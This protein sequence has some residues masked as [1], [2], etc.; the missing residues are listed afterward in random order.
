MTNIEKYN[1]L[2][3]DKF[4][5]DIEGVD[6]CG[7]STLLENLESE[8]L[9]VKVQ[10][11][12]DNDFKEKFLFYVNKFG[13][14][15]KCIRFLCAEYNMKSYC[16]NRIELV[17]NEEI[18]GII[19]ERGILSNLVYN[20]TTIDSINILI[21]YYED[22]LPDLII[23][24]DKNPE[25]C[26]VNLEKRKENNIINKFVKDNLN[27]IY[28]RFHKSIDLLKEKVDILIVKNV[29]EAKKSILNIIK[30]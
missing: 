27:I 23:F 1:M 29:E 2:W 19:R 17:E 18:M 26:L 16:E 25:E 10:H 24:I 14:T 13:I 20:C 28:D 15:N 22:I 12:F 8:R 4:I 3:I 9:P 5:I 21:K 6:G 7:K 11:A 30:K